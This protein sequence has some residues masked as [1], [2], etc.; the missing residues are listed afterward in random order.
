MCRLNTVT[1]PKLAEWGVQGKPDA[2]ADKTATKKPDNM[3]PEDH[4]GERMRGR[5]GCIPGD[6]CSQ[7]FGLIARVRGF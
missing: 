5:K 1:K 2:T 4:H 3:M 7:S 6:G